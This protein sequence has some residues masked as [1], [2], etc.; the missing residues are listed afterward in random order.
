MISAGDVDGIAVDVDTHTF[1]G[2]RVALLCFCADAGA[3]IHFDLAHG[4]LDSPRMVLFD[5]AGVEVGADLGGERLDA[6]AATSGTYMLLIG[7]RDGAPAATMISGELS[8]DG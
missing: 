6:T 3:A 8:L 5:P 1:W 7:E 4:D 2:D